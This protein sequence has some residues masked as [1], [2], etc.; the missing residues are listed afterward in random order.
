M[1]NEH[2]PHSSLGQQTPSE[3]MALGKKAEPI[4]KPDF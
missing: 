2:R 4:K 1:Y 3:F